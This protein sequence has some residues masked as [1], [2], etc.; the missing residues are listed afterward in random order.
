MTVFHEYQ[1]DLNYSNPAV[2]IEMIDIILFWANRG[3][4][5]VRYRAPGCGC[6]FVEKN[7][8]NIAERA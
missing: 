3:A 6:F 1:W 4:D 8:Y 2:L 7:R 5:I